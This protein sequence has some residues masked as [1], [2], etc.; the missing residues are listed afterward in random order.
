MNQ[1]NLKTARAKFERLQGAKAKIEKYI[2]STEGL[3][4]DENRNLRRH[5]QA[6]EIVHEVGLK[7]QQQLEYH[8]SN[9]VSLAEESVFE[10]PYK[11]EARFTERRNQTECDLW[12]VRNENRISPVDAA[13]L[14]SVDVA[15]FALRLAS[16][17]MENPRSRNTLIQ[18]EPFKHLKG[19]D[20]NVRVIAMVKELSKKLNIQI[21]MVHDERVPMSEIKKGA[22][23]IFNTTKVNRTS[24]VNEL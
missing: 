4:K 11:F 6:R 24:K 21:I 2:S 16:W 8:I 14:G 5:I 15:G 19:L 23:K 20:E 17:S 1:M 10:D 13:G 12:F 7:T 22:D 9:I 3:L 18:D